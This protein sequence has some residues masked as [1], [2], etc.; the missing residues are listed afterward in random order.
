[1]NILSLEICRKAA[2]CWIIHLK[3]FSLM[4]NST[5]MN[6]SYIKPF[7]YLRFATST[8]GHSPSRLNQFDQ[9]NCI[10][11]YMNEYGQ[12]KTYYGQFKSCFYIFFCSDQSGIQ[13]QNHNIISPT[14]IFAK[15]AFL[16]Y[17][18]LKSNEC[19]RNV[20]K[21]DYVTYVIRKYLISCGSFEHNNKLNVHV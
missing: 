7:E 18:I 19:N 10:L 21:S 20:S 2:F 11:Q 12:Y 3:S 17:A 6:T 4:Y 13:M 16:I 14:T 8:W 5:S 1:M 15:F 9:R